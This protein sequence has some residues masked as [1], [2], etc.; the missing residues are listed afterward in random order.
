L[1]RPKKKGDEKKISFHVVHTDLPAN[2][3]S[4]LFTE[5][6]TNKNSYKLALPNHKVIT[7]AAG[8]SFYDQILPDNFINLGICFTAV[9]WLS[10]KIPA[11]KACIYFSKTAGT[12]EYQKYYDLSKKDLIN[13]LNARAQEMKHGASVIFTIGAYSET[14]R[15]C[16]EGLFLT[17][18]KIMQ[19]FLKE[20]KLTD[21]DIETLA[22]TGFYRPLGLIR[23]VFDTYLH[24][25]GLTEERIERIPAHCPHKHLLDSGD[26]EGFCTA[27]IGQFWAVI[28]GFTKSAMCACKG[29][30]TATKLLEE[31]HR[32][33][34]TYVKADP[35]NHV[36]DLYQF[37]AVIRKN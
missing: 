13:F 33:F 21:K 35:Y 26:I 20:G 22:A 4:Q 15:Y 19:E 18:D 8:F 28:G 16:W 3:Y 6:G 7:T 14:K 32:R 10:E 1:R 31:Y 27:V 23:E 37:I 11:T 29:E 30:E 17:H 36:T 34:S 5:V 12:D 2:N 9:H 24:K 25:F